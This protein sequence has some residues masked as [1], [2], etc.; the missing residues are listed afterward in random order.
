[1][2]SVCRL[3]QK[4][5]RSRWIVSHNPFL[6]E[7]CSK[8]CSIKGNQGLFVRSF[9]A[10]LP[11]HQNNTHHQREMLI[12]VFG[13]FIIHPLAHHKANHIRYNFDLLDLKNLIRDSLAIQK[14][15]GS[16]RTTCFKSKSHRSDEF[17]RPLGHVID[18]KGGPP[19]LATSE[20]RVAKWTQSNQFGTP[21]LVSPL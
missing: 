14:T 12:Q 17:V 11:L 5:S 1:M 10:C 18:S 15:T 4:I 6:G 16:F 21:E 20:I 7:T 19:N 13:T 3:Y 8:T 2:G 9:S